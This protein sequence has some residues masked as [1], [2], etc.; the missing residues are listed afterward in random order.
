MSFWT[1]SLIWISINTLG[2]TSA[3]HPGHTAGLHAIEEQPPAQ[4]GAEGDENLGEEMLADYP[5]RSGYGGHRYSGGGGR[6]HSSYSSSSYSRR[7]GYVGGGGGSYSSSH[8]SGG[9]SSGGHSSYGSGGSYASA[10]GGA[11]RRNYG[12]HSGSASDIHDSFGSCTSKLK[13]PMNSVLEC[14][15]MSGCKATCMKDYQFPSGVTEIKIVCDRGEWKM[16]GSDDYTIPSCS[17]SCLPE[18]QNGGVCYTPNVC[19]CPEDFYGPYCQFELK[20]CVD[21]PSTPM[22]SRKSCT[23][24]FCTITCAVGHVLPD[25]S[26]TAEIHCKQGEWVPSNTNWLTV[27]DCEPSCDPPCLHGGKC[28]SFNKCQCAQEY[29]GP[30]CQYSTDSCNIRSLVFN[31]N[32]SCTGDE[33][34]LSCSVKCPSGM[35]FERE[36]AA[37]YICLYET[38]IF[39]PFDVPKCVFNGENLLDYVFS[40]ELH[41]N[42]HSVH[43][44]SHIADIQNYNKILK[45]ESTTCFSWQGVHYKTFDN[46]VLNFKSDCTYNLIS[47]PDNR[48]QIHTPFYTRHCDPSLNSCNVINIFINGKNYQLTTDLQKHPIVI[49][50]DSIIQ[51]P[52][53]LPDLRVEFG[54]PHSLIAHLFGEIILNWN[55][56][57]VVEIKLTNGRNKTI[58]LCGPING[59]GN[60]IYGSRTSLQEFVDLARVDTISEMCEEKIVESNACVDA[61]TETRAQKFCS[62]IL[63]DSRFKLCLEMVDGKEFYEACKWDYCA[64]E[65]V[66]QK[67]HSCGCQSIEMFVK[68]CANHGVVL[69]WWRDEN[70]CPLQCSAGRVYSTCG[71]EL[72]CAAAEEDV[73][74]QEGCFC[75]A[76]TYVHNDTCIPAEQ[77]PCTLRGKYFSPGETV[78]SECNTCTCVAGSW[79]CTQLQCVARCEAVGDP[80]YITFDRKYYD[81]MG[82][83][84][85]YLLKASN[86]S[87]SAE[88]VPCDG[89]ISQ[90]M[91]YSVFNSA[92][93]P[94]C[95]KSVTI[96]LGDTEI[97]LKQGKEVII[98]GKDEL[99]PVLLHQTYI[100]EA[101]S[102]FV[103]VELW[104][105]VEVWWDGI[106][107]VYIDVPPTLKGKTKGLCGTFTGN[108]KD[109]FLTPEGDI[110]QDAVAFANKWKT[111]ENCD[112][113]VVDEKID[114]C[115][116]NINNRDNAK[117]LCGWIFS[118]L[119][120]DC[121]FYV[122]PSTYYENCMYDMCSCNKK[123]SDCLCPMLAA[124][125]KECSRQGVPINWRASVRECGMQCPRGQQYQ[126]CGDSCI[127]SCQDLSREKKCSSHCLEGCYCP[128]GLIFDHRGVCIPISS[129]PCVL[130]GLEYPAGHKEVRRSPKG[131]QLCLCENARWKCAA[132][133]S[134][135]LQKYPNNTAEELACSSS[136]NLIYTH[137]EPSHTVTCQNMH[138]SH[139]REQSEAICYGGCVCKKGY[140]LDSLSGSCVRPDECPCHHGGQSYADG[141]TI[142][143]DCNTCTCT[144]GK[145][146]CTEHSCPGICST[147]GDSHFLTFDDHIFDFQGTCEF[148]MA[149]GA[150]VPSD[151]DCF[152]V[153][154][155]M[156]SCG[157]SGVSCSKSVTL[158]VGTGAKK[159]YIVFSEGK[160][161]T[162]KPK[163]ERISERSSGLFMFAEVADLGLVLQWDKGTRVTL[164]AEPKWKNKVK[165]LCG[166][167]N[168]NANDDFQTPSGGIN[169][170]SAQVFGD[171]WKIHD[172]C[173]E[174]HLVTDTC[175]LYPNR[176]R[177][178]IEKCSILK[179]HIFKSCHAEVS[180]D[181]YL[182][183]CI[184]DTCGCDEGGDC[185]CL[186]TAISAYVQQC[187]AHGVFIK[188]RSQELCPMQCDQTCSEYSAC[189]PTCPPETCD[190]LLEQNKIGSLCKQDICVEGCKYKECP[191]GQVYRNSSLKECVPRSECEIECL[192]IGNKT[193]YEGDFIEGD[194]C[195]S[196][197][198]S[199]HQKSCTGQP[200]PPTTLPTT[201]KPVTETIARKYTEPWKEEALNCVQGWSPWLNKHHPIVDKIDS[202]IEP[203]PLLIDYPAKPSGLQNETGRCPIEMITDIK[204]RTV[205]GQL[206][207][208]ETGE[209][210]ECSTERG[211]FCQNGCHDYEISVHCQCGEVSTLPTTVQPT[212]SPTEAETT[213]I[214]HSTY[215]HIIPVRPSEHIEGCGA[216]EEWDDCAIHCDQLCSYYEYVLHKNGTCIFG[217]KCTPGCRPMDQQPCPSGHRWRDFES[218]VKEADCTCRSHTGLMIKPGVVVSESACESCQ[219]LNNYYSCDSSLCQTTIATTVAPTTLQIQTEIFI[220]PSTVTPPERCPNDR[221]TSLLENIPDSAFTASS[222][223]EPGL[224]PNNAR[225]KSPGSWR[226]DDQD[227]EPYLQIDLGDVD[228]VYGITMTGNRDLNEHVKSFYVLYS[229]D[230][231]TFSYVSFMGMPELF[232]GPSSSSDRE[233]TVFQTPVEA[234]Y[235]RISPVDTVGGASLKVELLGCNLTPE[236]STIAPTVITT[237]KPECTDH[238]SASMSDHQIAVSSSN[239]GA[240]T[241][242]QI[243]VDKDLGWSPLISDTNQWLQFDFLGERILT[244]IIIR[245]SGSNSSEPVPP[246]WITSFIIKYSADHKEW[247]PL[248]NDHGETHIFDGNNNNMDKV[249][250]Y[251]KRPIKAR[252]IRII[253]TKWHQRISIRA[254]I[255]GCYEPYPEVTPEPMSIG[256]PKPLFPTEECNICPGVEVTTDI[257]HCDE[258]EW[259]DGEYCTAR[260]QCPCFVGFIKY[261]VG[262]VFDNEFC[263]KCV[264]GLNGLAQCESKQCPPCTEGLRA[265][266][267]PNCN[268]VCK[269]CPEDTKLCPTS[270]VCVATSSWCDGITDCPDDEVNCGTSAPPTT[271]TT[272]VVT[273]TECPPVI[274]CPEGFK[275]SLIKAEEKP[276]FGDTHWSPFGKKSKWSTYFKGVNR[277]SYSSRYKGGYVKNTNSKSF[278]KYPSSYGGNS[279]SKKIVEVPATSS[280]VCPEYE[281]IPMKESIVNCTK[282]TCLPGYELIVKES[283]LPI[284]KKCPQ[285][286]CAIKEVP[287]PDGRCNITGR[288]FTTFDGTDYKYDI[289]DHILAR[290]RIDNLWR[291]IQAKSCPYIGPCK[292]YLL[293]KF[294]NHTLQFNTDLSVLYNNY[295]YTIPQVQKIGAQTLEFALKQVSNKFIIFTTIYGFSVIWDSQ[296]NTKIIVPGKSQG[297]VD[298]LCGLFDNNIGND[299]T[300]PDREL[301]K[302]TVEFGDSWKETGAICETVVCPTQIQKD[303]WK[304][305]KDAIME[306]PISQ[307][308]EQINLEKLLSQCVESVCS[309]MENSRNIDQCRCQAILDAVTECQA[310]MPSLDLSLWRIEQD[311]PVECPPGLV[312]KECFKRM[313]EPCCSELMVS[314]ACPETDQCFPGCYCP[315]GYVRNGEICVKPTECRDCQCDGYG[316]SSRFVTYDRMDFKFKGNC[317]HVLSQTIEKTN[318]PKFTA[319]ITSAP[320]RD[321]KEETCLHMITLLYKDHSVQAINDNDLQ[322]T[323]KIDGTVVTSRPF[324]NKWVKLVESQGKCVTITLTKIHVDLEFFNQG[325]GFNLRLPSHLYFDR[326]EGICGRCNLNGAD[327]ITMRNGTITEDIDAFG[328]SWLVTDTPDI[329]GKEE[330]CQVEKEIECLPPPAHQDPCLTI[331]DEKIFGKCHAVVDPSSY[332][333]NCHTAICNGASIGCREFEAYARDCQNEGICLEWR[334]SDLCPYKCPEGLEY[335]PC[336]LGCTETCDNYEELR[337][338]PESCSSPRGDTCVCPDNKVLKNGTCIA[339]NKCVPC[340]EEGHYPGD[341]WQPDSCTECTCTKNNVN[342]HKIQ[343]SD[344]GSICE[345]GYKSVVVSGTEDDCCPQHMCVPE[346]TSGPICPEL[347][348]PDCGFGQIMKLE[349]TSSGCQEFICQ[350]KPKSEC[351]P[352]EDEMNMKRAPGMIASL[353]KS[354]CCP[355]V[356]VD[357]KPETCPA[358]PSC[359]EFHEPVKRDTEKCCPEYRCAIPE[360]RCLYEFEYI[361][362]DINGGERLRKPDER[363]KELKSVGDRWTDGPCRACECKEGSRSANCITKV[364]STPPQSDD[365]V[366]VP[367]AVTNKCCPIYKRQWCK[368]GDNEYQVGSVWPS[369]VDNPCINMTCTLGPN[370]EVTKQES[371]ESCKKDCKEGWQYKEPA[372]NSKQC[373]GECVPVGCVV[374]GVLHDKDSSWSSEDNCT[375]YLCIIAS[376]EQMHVVAT[377]EKCPFIDD[378]PAERV[379]QDNCCKK[380]NTSIAEQQSVCTIEEMPLNDTIG[381]VKLYHEE[382]G[383]CINNNHILGFNECRGTCDSYTEYNPKTGSHES[384]CL[385]CKVKEVDTIAVALTCDDGF[386]IEKQVPVPV[387]CLCQTCGS[388][389]RLVGIKYS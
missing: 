343:C 370:G 12:Y 379:Y 239:Q 150:T 44:H 298:G 233:T 319:L 234:K 365:Y 247:S 305:C 124:Y 283:E 255:L 258:T 274:N 47:D 123:P 116:R 207:V 329:I 215:H 152:S 165:G 113:A 285:Y 202:D 383:A 295:T 213:T 110:E 336:A 267:T 205:D 340:D 189:V 43:H 11:S 219:C 355:K 132:A 9:Y 157:S 312:Y 130:N 178:A 53:Q 158:S 306:E 245:G 190:N 360:N 209:D 373:C 96:T 30:Q 98:N 92:S 85:Y 74:C 302:T 313:C 111:E 177:W 296:G 356:V 112:N 75:P 162:S 164:R 377:Q 171:S 291:V 102:V 147:W 287:L 318:G 257:C 371:I 228:I 175:K 107:R 127:R 367:Q 156:V 52:S 353:D 263:E 290:D 264:C 310:K 36:P 115:K 224:E 331:L 17:P 56:E 382:H 270:Q 316:G 27:P 179:S 6:S 249:T 172:Y 385:C 163:L 359:P 196:C 314:D 182:E 378:C 13:A 106:N 29:R 1:V 169:E 94:S 148:V 300:K 271:P 372:K 125:A 332:V 81:F 203:L 278:S 87:I 143:N 217:Q 227:K 2:D 280:P 268:C 35:N 311:C 50:G 180:V 260:S 63:E 389:N 32:I 218:C 363:F 261:A 82:K 199:R 46:K 220:I 141:D 254:E 328:E 347:Q 317:T 381:I 71:S 136:K 155:E 223:L 293:V 151:E 149:K 22:N 181:A 28:M 4:N 191:E 131:P 174:S 294:A 129:C 197:Y 91:G 211:L 145:W 26:N 282:P 214:V 243:N 14:S 327:D 40:N 376:D 342:C 139:T 10:L 315:D 357:C 231:S 272:T 76:G 241:A 18:C 49:E 334:G 133:T 60:D 72:A 251:F 5:Y 34:A 222:Y 176:K 299:K 348:Q 99:L 266:L 330:S 187:N 326:T 237:I 73:A 279:Y 61:A 21:F 262:T 118:S 109:D 173:P 229:L 128:S 292:R 137:C 259:W 90:T 185:E 323:V 54:G 252:Y 351:P 284:K 354:G 364:C 20:R 64:C 122:E 265:E 230:N 361:E 39:E 307:C 269:P 236:I 335:R 79:S 121:H 374:D 23:A 134:D 235:I 59:M 67:N 66:G 19:H 25:G 195:Y 58:G 387:K 167:Y 69:P 273:V 275:M 375:T 303:A 105:G 309:C 88:N 338:N 349:K 321:N 186:C 341:K 8:S 221:F 368:E 24:E 142:Q 350:C 33:E 159:E 166:N 183:R 65:L 78:P 192:K 161:F 138:Y 3:Y 388:E 288:S 70:M 238:M 193:Y 15:S 117:R 232:K 324:N 386:V 126:T 322:V 62:R 97:K 339:E 345:R 198:C 206:S 108:Q 346:P 246:A 369:S 216:G 168:D 210:A 308:G 55:F 80:H 101:S 276:K 103:Q 281:C 146:F 277:G 208:K 226:P 41:T 344:S 83:C 38:G 42:S 337:T 240:V 333:S 352:V 31:G 114:P 248:T 320:C 57:D 358:P 144:S 286:T 154:I 184:F 362:D 188:W 200:C 244:G 250:Y 84:S 51:V 160:S 204:C 380:C 289:C 153:I 225:I 16:E 212:V 89:S 7:S 304:L 170:V 201:R 45:M 384:K 301:A 253:P 135:D 100:R 194:G 93:M 140:V 297:K 37:H 366:Y 242:D 86:Y 256:I 48:Y 119:F 77:C 120:L 325:N 104:D 95:T 68:Q